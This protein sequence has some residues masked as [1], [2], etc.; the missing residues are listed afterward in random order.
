LAGVTGFA[1][2]AAPAD[3]NGAIS[4]PNRTSK[5]GSSPIDWTT[6][7]L[8]ATAPVKP[9]DDARSGDQILPPVEFQVALSPVTGRDQRRSGNGAKSSAV[10]ISTMTVAPIAAPTDLQAGKSKAEKWHLR[11]SRGQRADG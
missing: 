6:Q 8:A 2:T 10:T 5:V 3:A 9:H 1:V 11:G 7:Y 4:A